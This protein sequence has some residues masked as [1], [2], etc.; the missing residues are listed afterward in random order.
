M[1]DVIGEDVR[2]RLRALVTE[3]LGL[4]HSAMP[5]NRVDRALARLSKLPDGLTA[6]LDAL[7]AIPIDHPSWQRVIEALVIGE[8][9]FFRQ[10]TWFLQLERHVLEPLIAK[11]AT[12]GRKRLRLWSAA[13]ATG[14]EAYTLAML[15]EQYLS[16]RAD[17][18][19]GIVA[20]DISESFLETARRG[21]YHAR[22]LRE[23]DP[24]TRARHFRRVD[25]E[26]FE[27]SATMRD[28]VTFESLNLA[29]E[30]FP[31]DQRFLDVD[32]IV[33]RNVLIYLAPEQQSR[34]AAQLAGRLG[35]GGWLAVAPAEAVADWYRPLIPLNVPSAIF[36][37]AAPPAPIVRPRSVALRATRAIPPVSAAPR[38]AIRPVD[39]EIPIAENV[40]ER[41]RERANRGDLAAARRDCERLLSGERLRYDAYL[42]LAL[43]CEEMRDDAAALEAAKRAIY[44]SPTSAPAHFI[45]GTT[46]ARM[47]HARQARQNMAAVLQL[48]D[49][50]RVTFS[51]AWDVTEER[52]R[53]AATEF[54]AAGKSLEGSR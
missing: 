21:I 17:W 37:Q 24:E 6:A 20:T 34:V 13:C 35:E 39:A 30:A 50:G 41:I 44:V 2:A 9:R 31:A 49:A 14:E 33:C 40:L 53:S 8:T 32:L 46:L 29:A 54:L 51:A 23:L 22:S 26:H 45:C 48:L 7:T 18:D 36:F 52:L 47:G 4:V 15:V 28:R 27:I 16:S 5:D 38:S 12:R 11:R 19:V 3:R 43:I 1:P 42:L 25:E 10:S